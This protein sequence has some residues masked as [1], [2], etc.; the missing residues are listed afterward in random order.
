MNTQSLSRDMPD[1]LTCKEDQ[2]TLQ[3]G[4]TKCLLFVRGRKIALASKG[5]EPAHAEELD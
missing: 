4:K 2:S 3:L 5:T 1:K